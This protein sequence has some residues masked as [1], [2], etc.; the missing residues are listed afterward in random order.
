MPTVPAQ[1]SPFDELSL[2]LLWDA[3]KLLAFV[4]ERWKLVVLIWIAVNCGVGL[5]F[6]QLHL[7]RKR[8]ARGEKKD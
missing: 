4:S 7:W 5:L 6:A 2:E 3:E 1:A 8:G